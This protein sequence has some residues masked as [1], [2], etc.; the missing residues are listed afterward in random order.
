MISHSYLQYSSRLHLAKTFILII[1]L[2]R[3]IKLI[4]IIRTFD[5]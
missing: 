3:L 1:I 2:V 4:E 5:F